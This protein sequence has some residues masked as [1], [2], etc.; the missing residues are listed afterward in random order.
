MDINIKDGNK[1]VL[2]YYDLVFKKTFSSPENIHISEGLLKDLAAYDPL[3]LMSVTSLEVETPYN[4]KDVN[5]LVADNPHDILTTEVDF[6]CRDQNGVRF[7]LEMQIKALSYLEER[8]TYNVAQ[9]YTQLYGNVSKKDV[10]YQNLQPVISITILYD[11]YYNDPHAIR[12][13]RPYDERIHAYKKNPNIGLEI[14]IELKKDISNL[15]LNLQH[16]IHYFKTGKALENAPSYIREAAKLTEI[17]SY[18]KEERKLLDRIDRA[19]QTLLARE[20]YVTE[21]VMKQKS[22]E[23]AKNLV[24]RG[25]ALDVIVEAT[26]LSED[27]ITQL[28]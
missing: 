25:I 6:A 23:I 14:V 8:L 15:P 17:T 3:G 27:E 22:I 24:N 26:G 10:K 16:W 9:K 20:H 11:N 5:Q 2:P 1:V 12:Y 28:K 13:L 19:Q 7:L 4:F 21:Q 18:T